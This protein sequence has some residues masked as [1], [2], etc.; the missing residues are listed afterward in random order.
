MSSVVAELMLAEGALLNGSWWVARRLRA[1][2]GRHWTGLIWACI[3]LAV[4]GVGINLVLAPSTGGAPTGGAVVVGL[5][6][7]VDAL[8]LCLIVAR[9]ARAL[10][11]SVQLAHA[12]KARE[13][14][15][16]ATAADAYA[17]AAS[18]LGSAW[19]RVAELKAIAEEGHMRLE[20]G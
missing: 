11:A 12:R 4:V 5:T 9:A 13:S 20:A 14:G 17:K 6:A 2:D 8:F 16:P 15:D 3:A 10:P 18:H 7:A 1:E 19:K